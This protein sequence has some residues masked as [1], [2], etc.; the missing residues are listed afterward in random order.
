MDTST[1]QTYEI[2][3]TDETITK[4]PYRELLGSHMYLD[5]DTTSIYPILFQ[6]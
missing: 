2:K 6:S 5:G 3:A 1:K 4:K